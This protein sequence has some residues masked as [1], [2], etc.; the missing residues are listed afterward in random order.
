[1]ENLLRQNKVP[2]PAYWGNGKSETLNKPLYDDQIY[3]LLAP[4][5]DFVGCIMRD[6]LKNLL[7]DMLVKK[8]EKFGFIIN[9]DDS[10]GL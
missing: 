5:K 9:T 8:N 6:E 1:L 3:G 10:K 4:Y 7:D 2:V